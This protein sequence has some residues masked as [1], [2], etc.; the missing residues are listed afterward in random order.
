MMSLWGLDPVTVAAVQGHKDATTT[1]WIYGHHY[2]R[3]RT[4]EKVRGAI[5]RRRGR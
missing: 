2:D 5:A 1:M 4:D 3:K